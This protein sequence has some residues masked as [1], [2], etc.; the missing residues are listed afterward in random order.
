MTNKNRGGGG[1]DYHDTAS[2]QLLSS[3]KQ[4]RKNGPY[5]KRKDVGVS[6]GPFSKQICQHCSKLV[7][8]NN[9]RMH[10][11][12]CKCNPEKVFISNRKNSERY[13]GIKRNPYKKGIKKPNVG[14]ALRGRKRPLTKCPHCGKQGGSNMNR[15]HFDN[16]KQK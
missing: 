11:L 12:Q 3:I 9:I 13:K 8:K 1:K 6:K 4:G 10:E 2:R 15:Y 14:I 5:K 16:C 7:G